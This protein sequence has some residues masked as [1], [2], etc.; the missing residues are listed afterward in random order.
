MEAAD[1]A[2]ALYRRA[3]GLLPEVDY[4]DQ[5]IARLEGRTAP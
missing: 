5:Q 3:Q 2:L 1:S 4:I